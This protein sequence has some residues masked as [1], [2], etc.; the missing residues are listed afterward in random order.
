MSQDSQQG[1][2]L[3]EWKYARAIETARKMKAD[4]MT[5]DIIAKYTGLTIDEID[6]L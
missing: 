3:W 1:L 6:A 5:A 2:T 4:G